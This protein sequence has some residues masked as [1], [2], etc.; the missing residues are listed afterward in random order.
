MASCEAF[1]RVQHRLGDPGI[2]AAPAEV[3]AHAFAHA[4]RVIAGL[5][6]PNQADRAHDLARRAEPALEAV[7][8][9][10]SGLHRMK[11]VAARDALDRQDIGAVVADRQSQARID[12]SA[13][14]QDRAGA[15]L[16][17]VASLLGSGQVQT[18]AQEIEQRDAGV[19]RVRRPAAR[20]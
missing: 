20:R 7:M 5:P 14:D 15:A 9:D 19:V 3:S 8:S 4:L 18:L 2:G 12:P 13:V 11:L 16:A 6:F 1:L 10:E 17:A